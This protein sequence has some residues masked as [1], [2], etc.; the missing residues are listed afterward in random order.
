MRRHAVIF[1]LLI[2]LLTAQTALCADRYEIDPA[3]TFVT[4][5]ID[6]L[7]VSKAKGSFKDVSGVILYDAKDISK[8]AVEVNIKTASIN[9]NNDARDKHLRSADFFDAEKYPEMTF[10]S[11]RVEK[12][13]DGF[14]AVG[15]LTIHG[16]TKEVTMPF[17]LSGPIKDP[18]GGTSRVGIEASLKIDRRD[19]GITWNKTLDA[20]GLMVGNDVTIEIN[21]EAAIPK[22]KSN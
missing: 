12:K 9:T 20:G 17:K 11:K 3:H 6:H 1:A 15:D 14:V 16:V 2:S 7:V 19:F 10:K 18:F 22:P 4:F 8:S 21:V 13:G 5:S